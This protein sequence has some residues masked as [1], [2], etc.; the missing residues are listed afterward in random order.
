M[1]R[2]TTGHLRPFRYRKVLSQKCLQKMMNE[3]NES[4]Q[5]C[6]DSTCPLESQVRKRDLTAI[7]IQDMIIHKTLHRGINP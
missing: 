5:L 1:S 7:Q 3:L 4:Q 6:L 2:D